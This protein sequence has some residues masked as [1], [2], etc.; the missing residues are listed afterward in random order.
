MKIGGYLA[1]TMEKFSNHL[2]Q[3][4]FFHPLSVGEKHH[5]ARIFSATEALAITEALGPNGWLGLVEVPSPGA[6]GRVVPLSVL[7]DLAFSA[8]GSGIISFSFPSFHFFSR[9]LVKVT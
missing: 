5:P 3:T 1:N 6:S 8:S 2:I 9:V 4:K 7:L